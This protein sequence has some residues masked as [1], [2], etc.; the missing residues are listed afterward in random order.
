LSLF[1]NRHSAPKEIGVRKVI[2][3][4]R[5]PATFYCCQ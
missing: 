3:A 5:I 1:G 4:V 2:G